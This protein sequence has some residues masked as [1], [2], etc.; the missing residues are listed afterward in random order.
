MNRMRRE[1]AK[2]IPIDYQQARRIKSLVANLLDVPT[3]PELVAAGVPNYPHNRVPEMGGNHIDPEWFKDVE[4]I[5]ED[6]ETE[7]LRDQAIVLRII[8]ALVN[9]GNNPTPEAVKERLFLELRDSKIE[10]AEQRAHDAVLRVMNWRTMPPDVESMAAALGGWR[11]RRK[12]RQRLDDVMQLVDSHKSDYDVD[13]GLMDLMRDITPDLTP[14]NE[15]DYFSALEAGKRAIITAYER[16]QKGKANGPEYPWESLRKLVPVIQPGH[17][18]VWSAPTKHGKTC[19]ANEIGRY[20]AFEQPEYMVVLYHLET[21]RLD[22][23]MREFARDLMIKPADLQT[24]KVD[25][26]ERR[27]AQKYEQK[28]DEF[29]EMMGR[30]EYAKYKYIHCPGLTLQGLEKDLYRQKMIA[31]AMGFEGVVAIVDY[32]QIMD[33][34]KSVGGNDEVAGRNELAIKLKDLFERANQEQYGSRQ[35]TVH[36]I[37]FAQDSISESGRKTPFGGTMIVQ[38]SQVQIQIIGVDDVESDWEV[39]EMGPDGR[40]IKDENGLTY[41]ARDGLGNP[42]YYHTVGDVHADRA[43]HVVRGNQVKPGYAFVRMTNGYFTVAELNKEPAW[44]SEFK[45]KKEKKKKRS[46]TMN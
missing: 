3:P 16:A 11:R 18:H 12:I 31:E 34:Q 33:W 8:Y 9:E 4:V 36:G 5:N 21:D 22:M 26:R 29:A 44:W 42:L 1:F 27:F 40:A 7:R 32:Y 20:I 37:V 10:D 38:R 24:G 2:P 30:G 19:F 45:A 14:M 43:I 13:I 17:M 46:L 35:V 15:T 25:I 39:L 23:A 41:P 28:Y 6:G